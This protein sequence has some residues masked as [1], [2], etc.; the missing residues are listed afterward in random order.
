MSSLL[1]AIPGELLAPPNSKLVISFDSAI[2]AIL[3]VQKTRI[4]MRIMV[5]N[6]KYLV[7]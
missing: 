4:V 6:E 3:L 1:F 7:I 5:V 2:A